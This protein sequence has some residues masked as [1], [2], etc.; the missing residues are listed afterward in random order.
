MLINYAILSKINQMNDNF[1]LL[2]SDLILLHFHKNGRNCITVQMKMSWYALVFFLLQCTNTIDNTFFLD[3]NIIKFSFFSEIH[4]ESFI[5]QSDI[6][7]DKYRHSCQF[8]SQCLKR[9]TSLSLPWLSK[10]SFFSHRH[11]IG[12][13]Y[14]I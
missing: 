8:H 11:F 9:R 2:Y 1:N 10:T 5:L 14:Q 4:F 13:T 7:S 6:F 12:F 3:M